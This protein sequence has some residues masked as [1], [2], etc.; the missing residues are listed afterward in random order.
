MIATRC[1]VMRGDPQRPCNCAY[2]VLV[3]S[4][5]GDGPGSLTVKSSNPRDA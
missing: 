5:S 3:L 4:V 2:F 1:A